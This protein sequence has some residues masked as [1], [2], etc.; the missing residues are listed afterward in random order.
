M[1]LW[2]REEREHERGDANAGDE[3]TERSVDAAD[4]VGSAASLDMSS[5]I[6]PLRLAITQDKKD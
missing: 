4:G 5:E 2:Y 1:A 3:S 6:L